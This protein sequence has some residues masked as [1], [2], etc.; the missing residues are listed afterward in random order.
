MEK[1]TILRVGAVILA[2]LFLF[3]WFH[4]NRSEVVNEEVRTTAPVY[5]PQDTYPLPVRG[6]VTAQYESAIA[7][8]QSGT[9]ETLVGREGMVVHQGDVL[10]VVVDPV[11]SA[12]RDVT[13]Y[14]GALRVTT[15]NSGALDSALASMTARSSSKEAAVTAEITS[16]ANA[17]R[18]A[19]LSQQLQATANQLT[20]SLPT[21][22]SF[23]QEN[24]TLFTVQSRDLYDEV[25]DALYGQ[26]PGQF[27]LAWQNGGDGTDVI[28]AL[29]TATTTDA[30]MSAAED[31]YTTITKLEEVYARSESVFYDRTVL[32]RDDDRLTTFATL[33]AQISTFASSIAS[34]RSQV[35]QM[36]DT[37]ALS[38]VSSDEGMY[39]A[40][41][42][43]AVRAEQQLYAFRSSELSTALSDAELAAADAQLA[44]GM[45]R[46]PYDGVIT[47]VLVD[48]G[49]FVQPGTP[50]FSIA[51]DG[52]R[53]VE[54]SVPGQLRAQLMPGVVLYEK[55][56]VVGVVDRVVPVAHG[57]GI[58]AF[59]AL[60]VAYPAGTTLTGDL[61]LPIAPRDV[62]KV[63]PRKFL[64]FA[65]TGPYVTTQSGDRIPVIVVHDRGD[66]LLVTL[67]H[68][69]AEDI[70]PATGIAL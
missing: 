8:K 48:P 40:D 45:I 28:M 2:L 17:N 22:L 25:T 13:A 54:V 30:V 59:I 19:E 14:G 10:A 53:E 62:L 70:L 55:G 37:T 43:S 58:T 31:L 33:R 50:L 56:E 12:Q 51:S 61:A 20:V 36:G 1:R 67:E 68:D 35:A 39:R 3:I 23:V 63:M 4:S 69:T 57:G 65:M 42:T 7:A 16:A 27:L 29:A 52:A 21:M 11:L 18:V 6:V 32:S 41:V 47:D 64:S 5:E 34:V 44:L 46:A 49:Q 9:V 24:R 26:T 66:E 38:A 15:A 60:S